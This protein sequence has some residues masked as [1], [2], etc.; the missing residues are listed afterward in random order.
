VNVFHRLFVEAEDELADES[1]EPIED[2]FTNVEKIF[3]KFKADPIYFHLRVVLE[4]LRL[5]YYNHY[6]L[7][8]K[9]EKFFDEVSDSI[10]SLLSSYTG[11]T[12][13]ARF[14]FTTLERHL[15]MGGLENL[16]EENSGLFHDF[17]A[18]IQNVPQYVTYVGYRAICMYYAGKY[19]D[20]IRW[21]NKLLNETNLKKY[22]YVS[23]DIKLLLAILYALVKDKD[24][25]NQ[26]LSSMQRQVRILSKE[27]CIHV[28][29]LMK[30][31]KYTMPETKEEIA[32]KNEK[33]KIAVEKLRKTPI[34]VGFSLVR[35]LRFDDDFAQK[36]I[37]AK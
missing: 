26:S 35:Y 21:L 36:L 25:L 7:Y 37:D 30:I 6:K 29:Q 18:D 27:T 33:I 3:N 12:Y 4:F 14:L 2:I 31:L 5:E 16:H 11:Q 19:E 1:I 24:L 28:V 34:P 20:A 32:D 10:S 17:E 13:G 22:A 8:R 9:A 15:R 23:L